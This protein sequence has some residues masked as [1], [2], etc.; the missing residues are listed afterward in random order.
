MSLWGSNVNFRLELTEGGYSLSGR[1]ANGSSECPEGNVNLTTT[2][3]PPVQVAVRFLEHNYQTSAT[4][5]ERVSDG[6]S[7]C[8]CL[9]EHLDGMWRIRCS[10][11]RRLGAVRD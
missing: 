3:R 8:S 2:F 6:S 7:E 11:S 4:T 5:K 1:T 9:S 10:G